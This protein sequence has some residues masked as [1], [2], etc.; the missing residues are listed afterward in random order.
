M[1]RDA[2]RESAGS[3]TRRP[4]CPAACSSRRTRCTSDGSSP[5]SAS[6][7]ETSCAPSDQSAF[8]SGAQLAEVE[9]VPVD[10]VDVAEVAGVRDLLQL[11]HAGVVL[12][13]VADHQHRAR[14]LGRGGDLLGIGRRLRERLLDEAVLA[15][16]QR[17]ERQAGVGRH[18]RGDHDARRARRRPA[19]RPR[20]SM[21][22]TP[23]K[24]ARPAVERLLRAVADPG[25]LGARQ[26]VEVAGEVRAP[27]AEADHAD[28]DGWRHRRTRFGARLAARHAAEVD[29]ERR[30]GE[31]LLEVEAR[32]GGDDDRAVAR[33]ELRLE[34]LGERR[35]C[36]GSS[37]T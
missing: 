11:D 24:R 22:R 27:V 4:R 25:Q 9:A 7:T 14:A 10:V 26:L 5:T 15:R 12:E 31:D 21:P 35:S 32:V 1:R 33:L 28:P 23:G 19:A 20:R 2:G 36:S 37:A 17:L 29:D 16:L 8:S 3:R 30:G 6:T 13:Q 34:R 18:G